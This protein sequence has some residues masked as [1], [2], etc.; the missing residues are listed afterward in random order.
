MAPCRIFTHHFSDETQILSRRNNK[1]LI[2]HLLNVIV[3]CISFNVVDYWD[4]LV[5]FG[6]YYM[7][8]AISTSNCRP[9]RA[10]AFFGARP[11]C[12]FLFRHSLDLSARDMRKFS[13]STSSSVTTVEW[14]S[15]ARKCPCALPFWRDPCRLRMPPGIGALCMPANHRKKDKMYRWVYWTF[16]YSPNTSCVFV[17]VSKSMSHLG[18][19]PAIISEH[20]RLRLLS[21]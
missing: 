21:K 18:F 3:Y 5:E 13:G 8:W 17:D 6:M 10:M 20:N 19:P 9:A 12:S 11:S 4:S 7:R 14:P 15:S 16:V 1:T 2:G